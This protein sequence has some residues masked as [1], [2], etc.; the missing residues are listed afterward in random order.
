MIRAPLPSPPPLS[1]ELD[2]A[3]AAATS[4]PPAGIRSTGLRFRLPPSTERIMGGSLALR[5]ASSGASGVPDTEPF[6]LT[7]GE[8]REEPNVGL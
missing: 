4:T 8:V 7:L 1:A 5:S 6:V 2:P 3:G